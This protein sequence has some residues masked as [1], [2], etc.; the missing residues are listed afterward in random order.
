M[1]IILL[2]GF[3]SGILLLSCKAPEDP[4]IADP[5][6]A[7]R[8]DAQVSIE[9][10]GLWS[11]AQP[12]DISTAGWEDGLYVSRDGLHLYATYIPADF[13]SFVLAEAAPQDLPLYA[14]GPEYTMDFL[15]NPTGE[16]YLWYQSDILY[17]SRTS[18]D[19]AFSPWSVSNLQRSVYSEGAFNA[20]F[21]DS[22]AIEMAIFTSNEEYTSLNNFKII[23]NSSANP[24]GIGEF[25]TPTDTLGTDSINT[26]YTEDNP[27]LEHLDGD[28][29]L[30]FF[31]SEDR[32]GGKGGHDIW[33][34]ISNDNGIS[35]STP[36]NANSL[37][38]SGKEHQPHL[39]REENQWY[40]YFSSPG[41]DGKLG[42]Y[43]AL[44]NISGD[45]DS[46]GTPEAVILAGNTAGI[47][48]PSLT[49]Q[50]DLYFTVI[51]ENPAG[52]ATDRY[53]ADPWM[54]ES[55]IQ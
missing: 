41:P 10:D 34:S 45:W 17:S 51:L 16:D 2:I 53:D 54:A 44:Q 55:L 26:L 37:N 20:V 12:L 5:W 25:I 15:T 21:S 31:D 19:Q 18:V 11:Q 35:W 49:S 9:L 48:E 46:W 28:Q 39:F 13:L 22:N 3:I 6:E 24:E 33:Y 38:T 14:R 36:L 52:S 40:L 50:G 43:R 23:R 27:H 30:L 4:A 29:W 1:R 42:I 8:R 47:G 7:V 32:P